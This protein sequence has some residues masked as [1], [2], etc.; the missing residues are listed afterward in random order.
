MSHKLFKFQNIQLRPTRQ[1]T[2]ITVQ[3]TQE[4]Q[5]EEIVRQA[6]ESA[7]R[8]LQEEE[9]QE[10]AQSSDPSAP[11]EIENYSFP[12]S[13]EGTD[14][15][16]VEVL[17]PN[18]SNS[19]SII[20]SGPELIPNSRVHNNLQ[21]YFTDDEDSE[22]PVIG[23]QGTLNTITVKAEINTA[24]KS[25]IEDS[26]DEEVLELAQRKIYDECAVVDLILSTKGVSHAK[27]ELQK[28]IPSLYQGRV[29]VDCFPALKQYLEEEV[30][31]L[32][33]GSFLR[34][35]LDTLFEENPQIKY[36]QE[37]FYA[38]V[39]CFLAEINS[40]DY[41]QFQDIPDLIDKVSGYLY[42]ADKVN[43]HDT[44]DF[45]KTFQSACSKLGLTN[46]TKT[47]HRTTSCPNLLEEGTRLYTKESTDTCLYRHFLNKS[48]IEILDEENTGGVTPRA[49]T[50]EKDIIV[51][52]ELKEIINHRPAFVVPPV[53]IIAAPGQRQNQNVQRGLNRVNVMAQGRGRNQ[54][55]LLGADPALIQILTR[56]ENRDTNRDNARKKFL[57]FPPGKFDGK[58]KTQAKAHWLEFEKYLSY[59]EQYDFVDRAD[60][61]E[62][63]RMFRLTLTE[64]ALGWYDSENLNWTNEDDMKQAFLQRFNVW[65]DTRR[66]QQNC[67]NKLKFNMATDDVDIFVADMKTLASILGFADQVLADKFKDVFPDRNIEAALVAMDQLPEMVTKAKQLVQIYR[68]VGDISNPASAAHLMHQQQTPVDTPKPVKKAKNLDN[69]QHQLAPI[70]RGAPSYQNKGDQKQNNYQGQNP[71][72]DNYNGRGANNNYQQDRGRGYNRGNNNNSY[73]G[74]NRRQWD[75]NGQNYQSRPRNDGQQF[76]RGRGQN[77]YR[78]RGRGNNPG[79]NNSGYSQQP[80]FQQG[81]SRP[82]YN[83]RPQQGPPPPPPP[84]H[85]NNNWQRGQTQFYDYAEPPRYAQKQYSQPQGYN[86]QNRPRSHQAG[87][88]CKLCGA[89]GHYDTQCEF[90][91][92]FLN[93]TT[94]TFRNHYTHDAENHDQ[95]SPEDNDDSQ[96][97]DQPFQ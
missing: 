3:G 76:S 32:P 26:E 75:N 20:D 52:N 50:P 66:Q 25:S 83:Q 29:D 93:R 96:N 78:G 30:G 65:G 59:H 5:F 7:I 37:F 22:S 55:P 46:N 57:M 45:D 97:T 74:Q 33:N 87:Y 28:L 86:P 19:S 94:E 89:T 47:V 27:Q 79:Y 31:T 85:Y 8:R 82:P 12:S 48:P 43:L 6:Q 81:D 73:R 64:H 2:N 60:F 84:P 4:Q 18:D 91:Y 15:S 95:W 17:N 23:K 14:S 56:M 71:R 21:D 35:G 49:S 36:L 51:C 63:T 70:G 72:R 90:A 11:L 1:N 53:D 62:V 9:K 69:N 44:T 61:D 40:R 39:K 13:A 10:T 67:W 80:S 42:A 24:P 38:H 58:D 77:N 92:D 16:S 34:I 88:V 68:P 41:H 54:N